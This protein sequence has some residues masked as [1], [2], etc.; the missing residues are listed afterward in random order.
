MAPYSLALVEAPAALEPPGRQGRGSG[1][2]RRRI[3]H[4]R[5]SDWTLLEPMAPENVVFVGGPSVA[6]ASRVGE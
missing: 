1:G 4:K 5:P 6:K 3:E 2:E